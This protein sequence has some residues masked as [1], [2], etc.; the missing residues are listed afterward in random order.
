MSKEKQLKLKKYYLEKIIKEIDSCYKKA[1]CQL[2]KN[3]LSERQVAK[4]TQLMLLSR[5]A[6]ITPLKKEIDKD[7]G[8]NRSSKP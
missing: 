1:F 2:T 8:Q 4:L 6:A 7:E 5:D 3:D